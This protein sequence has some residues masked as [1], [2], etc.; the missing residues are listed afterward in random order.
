LSYH[1]GELEFTKRISVDRKK[2]VTRYYPLHITAEVSKIIGCI[3][4]SIS[5]KII[6]NL[7]NSDGSTL[8]ELSIATNRSA[9][10]TSWHL[11][12]LLEAGILKKGGGGISD[13]RCYPTKYYYIAA[14][15]LMAEIL[16]KYVESPMD[17]LVSDYS[18]LMDELG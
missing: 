4:N 13:E 16:S 6:L 9:S 17:K 8:T 5:R 12:R 3:R 1:L 15:S 14:K 7:M 2:N 10:T 11:Q 18:D